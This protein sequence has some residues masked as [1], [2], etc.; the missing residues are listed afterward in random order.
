MF[1]KIVNNTYN[2]T[3]TS[4]KP[5]LENPTSIP[6]AIP[7]GPNFETF[8]SKDNFTKEVFVILWYKYRKN[9]ER[10]NFNAK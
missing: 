1:L 4:S 8:T 3:L 2:E 10:K 5:Q 7:I 6:L 9:I